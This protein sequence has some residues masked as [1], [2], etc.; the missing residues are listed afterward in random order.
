M[1][2]AVEA[3]ALL[4]VRPRAELLVLAVGQMR[5]DERLVAGGVRV[6]EQALLVREFGFGLPDKPRFVEEEEVDLCEDAGTS[7]KKI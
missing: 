3:R 7:G 6:G 2:P 1:R 5:V 4:E